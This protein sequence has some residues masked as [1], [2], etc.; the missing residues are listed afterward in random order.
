MLDILSISDLQ[1]TTAE[2]C[3]ISVRRFC[4]I[5]TQWYAI[6]D[7]FEKTNDNE[8]GMDILR[9]QRID[10]WIQVKKFQDRNV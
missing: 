4:A 8:E 3:V 5:G 10:K 6:G 2:I 1:D 7:V 9:L